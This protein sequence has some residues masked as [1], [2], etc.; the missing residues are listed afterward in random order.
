[1]LFRS[2]F[3]WAQRF[4]G[5]HSDA[6]YAVTVDPSDNILVTGTFW[7]DGDFGGGPLTSAGQGDVFVAK[8]TAPGAF[9]WAKRFGGAQDDSGRGIA[10]D[11]AGNVA[12]TGNFSGTAAFGTQTL[13]SSAGSAD[14]FLSRLLASGSL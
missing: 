4:G 2:A 7:V 14:V 5:T 12:V 3:A 13:T 6:A 1:M 9:V 8:Y 11:G 10:V